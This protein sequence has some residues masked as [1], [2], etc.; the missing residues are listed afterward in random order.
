MEPQKNTTLALTREE[1]PTPSSSSVSLETLTEELERK[2][3][4]DESRKLLQAMVKTGRERG[5]LEE[6]LAKMQPKAKEVVTLM[7]CGGI[8][9]EP[10]PEGPQEG[11]HLPPVAGQR[12]P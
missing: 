1:H 6:V 9:E 12:R 3:L 4:A 10:I 7:R 5:T 8:P 11:E 2:L